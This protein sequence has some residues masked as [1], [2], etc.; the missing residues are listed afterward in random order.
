MAF[1][2]LRLD[3]R[4]KKLRNIR[5]LIV[6][7]PYWKITSMHSMPLFYSELPK[8]QSQKHKDCH[9][10]KTVK[11]RANHS[12]HMLK[13]LNWEHREIYGNITET[14]TARHH[15]NLFN[16]LHLLLSILQHFFT[17]SGNIGKSLRD[18]MVMEATIL[19]YIMLIMLL[20]LWSKDEISSIY[21]HYSD[22][23]PWTQGC[24]WWHS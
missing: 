23:T 1:S 8:W 12:T 14:N 3:R 5:S 2:T 4:F 24:R 6:T 18:S 17:H 13:G 15:S 21:L 19:I 11:D 20:D 9:V 10:L 16:L 22:Y 7:S